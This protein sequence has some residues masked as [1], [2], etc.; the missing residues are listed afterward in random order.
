MTRGMARHLRLSRAPGR[1]NAGLLRAGDWR[2]PCVLG[3]GG[4]SHFKRE[5]DGATPAA[6]L[7]PRAVLYRA[8][9]FPRP[10]TALPLTAITPNDGWCDDPADRNYNRPVSLPYPGR[11][12][13]L[14]RED[15]LYD[16]LVVLDWNLEPAIKGRGSAIFLH[17]ANPGGA[18][19]EGC[20]AVAPSAMHRL[21]RIMTRRTLIAID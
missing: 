16:L 8:D 14:W 10:F 3:R 12:E 19:T 18:P 13:R 5:G 17:L 20:I 15:H 7:H 9:R 11:H 4:I 1:R 6:R 21:L 2:L